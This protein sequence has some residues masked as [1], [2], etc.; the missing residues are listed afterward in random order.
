MIGNDKIG[1]LYVVATPIG[2]LKDITL[3]AIEILKTVDLVA[4][5]DTRVTG[6]LLYR[7]KIK[8]PMVSYHQHSTK[9]KIKKIIENLEDGKDVALTTDSG[10][11][12]ISDPGAVLVKRAIDA[13]IK[14]IP[15]PGPS[16][17]T[18]V[19]SVSGLASKGILFLG[20]LPKKKGRRKK[21]EEISEYLEKGLIIVLYESPYRIK[22]TLRE[23]K[24]LSDQLGITLFR[25]ISK[26]FEETIYLK[27][28]IDQNQIE[29]IKTKGEFTLVINPKSPPAVAKRQ[30]W[31]AGQIPN[32]HKI[33]I[34]KIQNFLIFE[35]KYLNL[36]RI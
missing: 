13:R 4:C 15:I 10:T 9:E 27:S 12:G 24:L 23:L 7:Y 29:N 22:R 21:F 1:K 31:R 16:A 18:A 32:K 25:E 20:F 8:V 3:R 2:T 35:F 6:R 36:F 28:P 11:P 14:I 17:L 33:Q 19:L 5:E 34:T 30:L 26:K